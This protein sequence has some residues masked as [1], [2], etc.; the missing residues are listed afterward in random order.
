MK[1][2]LDLSHEQQNTLL[3]ALRG[4]KSL[5]TSQWAHLQEK[6]RPA[7]YWKKLHQDCD[8]LEK[9]VADAYRAAV[10]E[11]EKK[12]ASTCSST[13]SSQVVTSPSPHQE[14]KVAS[15]CSQVG[16]NA[17]PHQ[18]DI[19]Q[20]LTGACR[21]GTTSIYK[22]VT[23][24]GGRSEPLYRLPRLSKYLVFDAETGENV[25]SDFTVLAKDAVPLPKHPILDA[26]CG[27][28]QWH[29][30][31]ANEQVEFMDIREIAKKPLCD[32]RIFEVKPTT[33]GDF[34]KMP[35]RDESFLLVLFDPPHRSDLGEGCWLEQ[36]FGN[37]SKDKNKALG[38]LRAGFNECWRVLAP[39]G[40]LFFKWSDSEIKLGELKKRV[41]PVLPVAGSKAHSMSGRDNTFSL[42]F[43]KS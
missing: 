35:F 41:F 36:R 19:V 12:A 29:F 7:H 40:V 30:D 25:T 14:E 2:T 33:V 39:G 34:T 17:S 1:I 32:G 9:M 22:V 18:S 42:V 27:G 31:K 24:S 21:P 5:A 38:M 6:G 8:D 37:L 4:K 13:S 28:R 23:P 16:T 10:I 43:F 20:D 26:C 3:E 11:E 15:T